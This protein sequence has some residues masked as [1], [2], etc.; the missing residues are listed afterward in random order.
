MAL[1]TSL[2]PR[3]GEELSQNQKGRDKI[4]SAMPK[5]DEEKQKSRI[6]VPAL[7]QAVRIM[8]YL[9]KNAGEKR[10]LT[11]ICNAVGIHKS[12]GHSILTILHAYDLVEKD[13]QTKAYMLGARLIPLARAVLDHLDFRDAATPLVK[14][15]ARETRA[16]A[17]FALKKNDS[18]FVV[19]KY[20]GGEHYWATPGIGHTFNL[21]EGAHGKSVL[22]FLPDGEREKLLSNGKAG[23]GKKLRRELASVRELGLAQDLGEFAKGINAVAAPV[24]GP[25]HQIGGVLLLFGTFPEEHIERY[26]RKTVD[27]AKRIS[28][29]LGN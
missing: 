11:R 18:L 8:L 26:G 3:P 2:R 20:E 27:A 22:A 6:L 17:W 13:P 7:D 25:G 15:L 24:F 4:R 29:K 1:T 16:T 9:E 10:S 19:S 21:F 5:G 12:K 23:G 14:E 28:Q